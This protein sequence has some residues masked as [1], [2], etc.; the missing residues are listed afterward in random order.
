MQFKS[1]RT[2]F[3]VSILPVMLIGFFV[4]FGISYKMASDMLVAD[5]DTIGKG[6]GK[7]AALEV[8]RLFD[9]NEVHLEVAARSDAIR[10]G[11]D[12]AK[13]ARMQEIKQD[14]D[15]FSN[16]FYLGVDGIGFDA[17]GSALDR[18]E[19]DYF[20]K[21][22][23]T[24]KTVISEPVISAISGKVVTIIAVPVM[25]NGVLT[26]IVAGVVGLDNFNDTLSKM[27][28]YRT[29]QLVVMDETG[30]VIIHP[31]EPA[32]VGKLD[33][34]K[35]VSS[36]KISTSLVDAFK[37]VIDKDAPVLAHYERE[38]GEEMT[39]TLVPI[40][41]DGRRWVVMSEASD[42]EILADAH[43]LLMVLAGLTV[44]I[45]LVISVIIFFVSNS[46]AA[47]V[48]KAVRV[49]EVINSGDL[50]ETPR[51]ITSQDE[52]GQLS[53]G[54]IKMRH[55]L[56]TLIQRIQSNA[57]ELSTSAEGLT[58]ASQQSAEASNH[59]A[60]SITEIAE[61]VERQSEA[62]SSVANA[63]ASISSHAEKMSKQV[64]TVAEVT[65]NTVERVREG[66]RSI[67]EVVKY[68]EQI[69]T[70]S[71]T[72]DAAIS[73]LGKSSEE[74][75][76]SVEV[77]GSI[78]EQTNLLAL[79][80]AIEAARAGEHG[81]GF[82]VVAEE[83]RKLAEESGEFSKKISE[84]MQSVQ[85]DMERAIDAGKHGDEY[86]GHGLDSVRTADEVFQSIA[87]SIQQLGDGVKDIT[88]GIRKMEDETQTVRAQ[89]EEIQKV[90]TANADGAQNVSAATEEQSA[91]MQEIAAS[92]RRL[93]G[94]ADELAD[95]T[96][97]FKL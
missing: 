10:H 61:G 55:T 70:G 90:S 40:H 22:V 77:I 92:T 49:C 29:G 81:R 50:R 35:E 91:S 4:F 95:E 20:K 45:L 38:S 87:E 43:T 88:A 32:Q 11:D 39:G 72:V 74:I 71:E 62:S 69:K 85:A 30:L 58:D 3:L 79:N 26:G 65:N 67:D 82:A 89:I 18:S 12:A 7:Q 14:T 25:E 84:T 6:V 13:M 31:N 86:V 73:A 76:H 94:L 93:S 78:A 41:L 60:V 36:V 63:T 16:I 66:R 15:V 5:A 83:V 57:A 51:T 44:V 8:Q 34:S 97:K 53:D 33:F 42:S 46:F 56:N 17:D 96:K 24:Q 28:T 48:Q 1:I 75:S 54:L 2:K 21:V 37:A 47:N 19:R 9:T 64:G 59:V 80:A 52:M 68:M 23:Q 27:A